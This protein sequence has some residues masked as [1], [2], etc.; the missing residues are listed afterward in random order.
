MFRA[1]TS[2]SG[3][4]YAAGLRGMVYRLDDIVKWVRLDKGIPDSFDITAIDGFSESDVYAA[5]YAGKVWHFD[6]D[7]WS[8]VDLPTNVNLT[9]LR[10]ASDGNV[11][12]GGYNGV[13]IRGR[14][15]TWG[16]IVEGQ[17]RET[18]WDIEYFEGRLFLSTMSFV[19]LLG[20]EQLEIVD[21]GDDPPETCYHLSAAKGAMWSIGARDVMSFDG[22][23]WT[24]I[25]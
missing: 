15:K 22:T 16:V 1:V 10:C 12:V 2:I 6:G 7:K 8:A 11:Y 14:A 3:K 5:G 21:F 18:F 17:T 25:V 19:Y 23:I 9:S 24:R 4:A 13:L 20:D